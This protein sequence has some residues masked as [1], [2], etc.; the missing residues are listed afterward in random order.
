MFSSFLGSEASVSAGMM[1]CDDSIGHLRVA[2]P[3]LS[4]AV[5]LLLKNQSKSDPI[6]AAVSPGEAVST[7]HGVRAA[8]CCY[9]CDLS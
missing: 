6:A 9:L 5:L 7:E 3:I 4:V 2:I 1:R 8:G